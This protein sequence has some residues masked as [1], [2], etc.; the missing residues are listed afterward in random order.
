MPSHLLH[1]LTNN[2]LPNVY[3]CIGFSLFCSSYLAFAQIYIY[4]SLKFILIN[5]KMQKSYE[6][7][8]YK[9]GLK[10]ADA[11]LKKFPSH[12][13]QFPF[14]PNPKLF[15]CFFFLLS[16]YYLIAISIWELTSVEIKRIVSVLI[17]AFM[18]FSLL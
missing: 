15:Y 10:A 16:C 1:K 3:Y 12:G 13:G 9:K 2:H 11:I 7:K 17:G 6:T 14:I 4:I 5:L 18:S 8:Q